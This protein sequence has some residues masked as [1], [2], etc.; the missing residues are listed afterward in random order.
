MKKT[1]YWKCQDCTRW[2]RRRET[3]E[4]RD[5]KSTAE[6]FA[7]LH[8]RTSADTPHPK[9][10]TVHMILIENDQETDLGPIVF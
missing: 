6:E 5:G 3:D 8:I 10:H 2:G 9:G 1:Y 4:F 7:R